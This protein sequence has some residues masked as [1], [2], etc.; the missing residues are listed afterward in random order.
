MIKE[1]LAKRE[2]VLGWLTGSGSGADVC[3]NPP[4]EAVLPDDESTRI[5]VIAER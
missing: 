5:V 3:L 1:G 4:R 2:I